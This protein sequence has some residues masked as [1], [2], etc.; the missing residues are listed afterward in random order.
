MASRLLVVDDDAALNLA[1]CAHFEDRGWQT[2]GAHDCAAALAAIAGAT[3]DVILLDVY[4][5]DGDGVELLGRLLE[6]DPRLPVILMTGGGD[7]ERAMQAIA[8]GAFDWLPKPR[9]SPP[10]WSGW[11][12]TPGPPAKRRS[13]VGPKPTT[14]RRE[15]WWARAGRCWKWARPWF[16]WRPATSGC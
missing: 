11:W 2:T 4:L 14:R 9:S 16:G 6:R 12:T 3:F 8:A 5:P 10:S 13:P 7:V 1:L 15:P